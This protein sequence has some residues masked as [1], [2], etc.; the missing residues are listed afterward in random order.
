MGHAPVGWR[1]GV[2]GHGTPS[3]DGAVRRALGENRYLTGAALSVLLDVHDD[4]GLFLLEAIERQVDQELEGAE[5]LATV[6][7]DEA[8][9]LALDI[10][11]DRLVV[12]CVGGPAGA[13]NGW[14][15]VDLHHLQQAVNDAKGHACAGTIACDGR[16]ADLGRFRADAQDARAPIANDVY[17]YL[18]A[19]DAEFEER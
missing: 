12:A 8:R 7:D 19:A 17:L 14:P 5:R 3:G 11:N 13:P 4:G 9:V 18:V 15:G 10:D 1:H 16:D 2:H 6:T